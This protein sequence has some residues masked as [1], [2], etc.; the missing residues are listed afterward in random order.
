MLKMSKPRSS[1]FP[2]GASIGFGITPAKTRTP[3]RR[4]REEFTPFHFDLVINDEAHRSIYGDAREVVQFFQA[5]RIGLTATPR[6]YLKNVNVE[7]LEKENPKALELRL[8]RD[9]YNYFGCKPGFPT[10]RY[11]IIDA[12]KDP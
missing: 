3:N 9:T 12:V 10:F 4:Y 7:E 2:T 6:A 8:L 11:D 1:F 5:T